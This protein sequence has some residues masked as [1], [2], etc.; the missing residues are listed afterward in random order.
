MQIRNYITIMLL[1]WKRLT[2]VVSQGNCCSKVLMLGLT[3]FYQPF[4]MVYFTASLV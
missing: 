1:P 3:E 2:K 4:P